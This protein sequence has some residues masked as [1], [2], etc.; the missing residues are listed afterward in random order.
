MLFF[1]IFASP[2]WSPLRMRTKVV[3]FF[4]FFQELSNKKKIKALRPKMTKIASRGPGR[5]P[6]AGFSRSKVQRKRK[7]RKRTERKAKFKHNFVQKTN[8]TKGVFLLCSIPIPVYKT[9]IGISAYK[10]N[11][12]NLRGTI[13]MVTKYGGFFDFKLK[14]KK[15]ENIIRERNSKEKYGRLSRQTLCL[16]RPR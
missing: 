3:S 13:S 10:R 7:L 12:F 1:D 15:Y 11:D 14:R 2:R 5:S 8:A 9:G 16:R 6:H 4:I